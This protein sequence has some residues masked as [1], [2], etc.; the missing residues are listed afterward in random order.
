MSA[1]SKFNIFMDLQS[2]KSHI[3]I[4]ECSSLSF[5]LS[6]S[7]LWSERDNV[8]GYIALVFDV[9]V[10]CYSV[11]VFRSLVRSYVRSFVRSFMRSFVRTFVRSCA[12][13][14][15]GLLGRFLIVLVLLV[16]VGCCFGVFALHFRGCC[17]LETTLRSR[18]A[19]TG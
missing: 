15:V 8:N 5:F 4:A 16:L 17:S 10:E 14:F 13:S 1:F 12:H 7:T 9:G 11:C 6:M 3:R 19:V 2:S 18:P